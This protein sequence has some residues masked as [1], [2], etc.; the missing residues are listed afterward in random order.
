MTSALAPVARNAVVGDAVRPWGADGALCEG[1]GA[2]FWA[3]AS[4]WIGVQDTIV[5]LI[6]AP[7]GS[8]CRGAVV[9]E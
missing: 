9:H 2:S 1:Q 8:I 7:D 6:P 5:V 3:G 4:A